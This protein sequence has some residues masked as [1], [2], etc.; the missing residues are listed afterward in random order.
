ML[1][2]IARRMLLFHLNDLMD[3]NYVFTKRSDKQGN[4]RIIVDLSLGDNWVENQVK[5]LDHLRRY[6]WMALIGITAADRPLCRDWILQ[7]YR[8]SMQL[9]QR[10][11]MCKR[12][13]KRR[14]YF[15]LWTSCSVLASV[16]MLLA[17]CS[18]LPSISE[19]P[20]I[21]IR[22]DPVHPIAPAVSFLSCSVI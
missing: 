9:F 5:G 12:S 2:N 4:E 13:L 20:D 19:G 3:T 16:N 17:F 14:K 18:L 6:R 8:W 15:V 7:Y 1:T 21:I 11:S 10:K 22:L